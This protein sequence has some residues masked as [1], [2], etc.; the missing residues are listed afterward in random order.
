MTMRAHLP[1]LIFLF[2]FLTT[3]V[4]PLFRKKRIYSQ[5][6]AAGSCFASA[7]FSWQAVWT[8]GTD[9]IHY[10]MGGWQAPFGIEWYLD[11]FSALMALLISFVAGCILAATGPAVDREIGGVRISFYMLVLLLIAGLLGM[12]L[13][14]DLFNL[15]V[16]VEVTSLTG[17]ALI[18]SGSKPQSKIASLRYLLLGTVGASLYLLG[19]GY[20]YAGTGTLNMRDLAGLFPAIAESRTALLGLF[21]IVTGLAIKMGLF[22]FHG[23]LPDAYTHASDTVSA[24]VAPIMTKAMIY[25]LF[26]ILYWAVPEAYRNAF[27]LFEILTLLGLLALFA[28]AIMA[29]LQ[30]DFKRMLA[31][32]SISQIGLIVVGFSLRE[33]AAFAGAALHIVNHACMKAALFLIAASAA[34]RHNVRDIRHFGKLRG[35]MPWTLGAFALAALSMVGVPPFGGFFS[36]WY[37]LAGALQSQKL[38]IAGA[39][40]ASSLLTALYFFRVIEF[41][42]FNKE[43]R[44]TGVSM[45]EAPAALPGMALFFALGLL[46]LGIAA[47]VLYHWE[48]R[49]LLPPGI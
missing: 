20:L 33:P 21:L 31:Y 12:I 35:R 16:F 15:F 4:L 25:S 24:L 10:V 29:F 8:V 2:P 18:A 38:W 13:T 40:A 19:V 32:S 42:F 34:F 5:I 48:I 37:I 43:N 23:W 22:P 49:S 44:D 47:P 36:K 11:G 45:E 30:K 28:G 26:R 46:V 7:W 14:H 27:G 1:V 41:A 9:P 39:V 6:L 17:Y 3:L